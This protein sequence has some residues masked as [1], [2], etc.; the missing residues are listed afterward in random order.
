MQNL[1]Q[2]RLPPQTTMNWNR[3]DTTWT[4][5]LFGT[6]IGA[7]VL[8]FPIKV[9]ISGII[10]MLLMLI[11]AWPIAF[12]CHR[13]LARLCLSGASVT[14]DIT[15]TVEQHF[16]K[17]GGY[18]VTLLYFFAICPLLWIYG[19]GLTNTFIAFWQEQLH[20]APVN[21]ALVALVLL[22]IIYSITLFGKHI[23][24]KLMSYLVLPFI[25][26][27]LLVSLAL[28]PYW[29][30]D[31]LTTVP[32]SLS[33]F[34]DNGIVPAILGGIAIMVF[35]F[36]FSPIVSTFVISQRQRYEEKENQSKTW[37]ERKCS[38]IISRASLLIVAVVMFFT[39]SCVL[40]LST[41]E[42]LAAKESNI[43]VLSYL[44]LHFSQ[45]HGKYAFFAQCLAVVAPIIA[46]VAIFKSF[47]GHYLGTLEGLNG[48]LVKFV[49]SDNRN[50]TV[51]KRIHLISTVLI[52][53]STWVIA[54][55]NPNILDFIAALGAP[56]IALLLCLL[57][58]WAIYHSPSLIH[59]RHKMDNY[60]VFV[61]GV[62]T[63]TNIVINMI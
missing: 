19:V 10:P 26:T 9:G 13:A 62:L 34:T 28:I 35:S 32:I 14:D 40:T 17:T 2:K 16:G 41:Q 18:L 36:N 29:H 5:G 37:V 58:I 46:F 11:L 48:L 33:L 53:L 31:N 4:L 52:M 44:A 63:I 59:H 54:D 56:V 24:I 43:S 23:I 1:N 39:L 21:R 30:L 38:Q 7:G 60:F 27:L 6:A 51:L 20:F 61:I 22:L 50:Q 49:C 25:T 15:Q 8:F 57:P 12:F 55:I 42:L 47:F 3:M 45:L